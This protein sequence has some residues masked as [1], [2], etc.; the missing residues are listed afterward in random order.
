MRTSTLRVRED[1]TRSNSPLSHHA[2]QLRLQA[3]GDV[4]D[5][6]EEQGAAVRHLEPSHAVGLGVR[7]R[8]P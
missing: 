7:E 4:R 2:Q 3:Q 6:V 8:R 5:L 1:P